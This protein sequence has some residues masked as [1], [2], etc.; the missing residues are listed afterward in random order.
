MEGDLRTN[1]AFCT[2]LR[3][4][5]KL[6]NQRR[7]LLKRGACLAQPLELLESVEGW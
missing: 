3:E 5:P 7:T 1:K 6:T 4:E 2:V